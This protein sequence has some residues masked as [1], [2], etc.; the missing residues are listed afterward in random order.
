MLSVLAADGSS[1][2]ISGIEG[3]AL[4]SLTGIGV[5]APK[6]ATNVDRIVAALSQQWR[7]RRSP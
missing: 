2:A 5:Y 4:A 1:A 6:V 7:H 3:R